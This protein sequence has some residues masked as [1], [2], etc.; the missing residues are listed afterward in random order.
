MNRVTS[1]STVRSA[2]FRTLARDANPGRIARGLWR[3]RDLIRQLTW[4]EITGRYR[5][6][7]LGLLWSFITP[8]VTLCL[9]TFVF[10]VVFRSRWPGAR[11]ES[12]AEFGL[13]LFAGLAAFTLFSECVTRAPDLITSQPNYVKKVVFPLEILPVSVLGAAFVHLG[14]SVLILAIAQQVVMGRVASTI[15]LVPVTLLPLALIALGVSW[16]LASMG[17]F[18]RDIGPTVTL[19]MQVLFFTTPIFYSLDVVPASYRQLL[20]YN[21][22]T[23]II[24]DMRRVSV[25]GMAPDWHGLL[26]SLVL[27]L[28]TVA[29]GHAWFVQTKRAFADVI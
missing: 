20:R 28:L 16:M 9:Y 12:L 27:G 26:L 19:V 21:P 3:Q 13:M 15:L 2:G 4:R 23:P 10:G 25:M 11:T 17:V 1:I 24:E 5:S 22:L 14:I 8:L 18:L 7:V 29:V 6:S